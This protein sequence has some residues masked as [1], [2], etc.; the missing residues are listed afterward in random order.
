MSKQN[1]QVLL[2]CFL[3]PLTLFVPFIGNCHLFEWDEI[4]FAECAREMLV[5]N[6]Y[7]I[8]QI[9]F[10][11]FWEKPPLFFWLQASCMKVFGVGEFAARLPN[12]LLS[13]IQA[14]WMYR[15]GKKEHSHNFGIAWVMILFASAL[16]FLYFKSGIIDPWFNFFIVAAIV[17]HHCYHKYGKQLKHMLGTAAL[18]ALAVLTKGPVALL[19]YGL[20][21]LVQLIAHGKKMLPKFGHVIAGII[22]FAAIGCIWLLPIILKG[23]SKLLEQFV[24]Y[25]IRLL[26]TPDAGHGGPWFYHV[27]VILFGVMPASLIVVFSLRDQAK[28]PANLLNGLMISLFAI[29]LIV[30]SIVNTKIVHY[31]SICYLPLCYWAALILHKHNYNA[32]SIIKKSGIVLAV[33]GILLSLIFFA[34]PIFGKHIAL[35]AQTTNDTF[36]QDTFKAAVNWPWWH[37]IPGV[38]IVAALLYFA[39]MRGVSSKQ[40]PHKAVAMMLVWFS[41]IVCFVKTIEGISQ[42]AEISFLKRI[43]KKDAY[44]LSDYPNYG[45]WFYGERHPNNVILRGT[46]S[47]NQFNKDLYYLSRSNAIERLRRDMPDLQMLAQKNGYVLWL[48]PSQKNSLP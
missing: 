7:A 19:L 36:T 12:A 44:I 21:V 43:A 34:L 41:M 31:S 3:L 15:V 37:A 40:L 6:N 8:P 48:K 45:Q 20:T 22:L 27:I 33:L 32:A 39:I 5:T 26:T 16:P 14:L 25:Q 18:L 29:G 23:D 13:I 35:L 17:Q 4:N 11:N 24:S 42:G 46:P 9:N 10:E 30:F 47:T 2:V 28:A 38:I 1:I